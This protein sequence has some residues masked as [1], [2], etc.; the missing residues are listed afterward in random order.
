MSWSGQHVTKPL[1]G[2]LEAF[3]ATLRD[4]ARSSAR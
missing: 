4:A 2:S 1:D 3:R